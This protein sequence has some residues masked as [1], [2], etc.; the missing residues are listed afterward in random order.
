VSHQANR[1]IILSAAER[2]GL[3]PEKVVINIERYGN[4][5][6]GTIPLALADAAAEGRLKKGD[7]VLLAAVGA[8]FTSG[9]TLLR[10]AI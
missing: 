10:W 5:T 4:T 6:A 2:L 8:G 1:R 9:A 7:L 3:A